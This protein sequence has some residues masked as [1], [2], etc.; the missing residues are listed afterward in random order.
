MTKQNLRLEW[1]KTLHT[2]EGQNV[3]PTPQGLPYAPCYS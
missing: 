2:F 1:A 3:G